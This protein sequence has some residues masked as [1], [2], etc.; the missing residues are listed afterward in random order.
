MAALNDLTRTLYRRDPDLS[1]I[2]AKALHGHPEQRR[3]QPELKA[4]VRHV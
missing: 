2:V 3:H 1:D 4:A